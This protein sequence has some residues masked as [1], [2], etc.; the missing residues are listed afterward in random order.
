M[1][2]LGWW[3]SRNRPFSMGLPIFQLSSVSWLQ[4][5]DEAGSWSCATSRNLLSSSS[6][7]FQAYGPQTV[8]AGSPGYPGIPEPVEAVVLGKAGFPLAPLDASK[9]YQGLVRLPSPWLAGYF[10][11]W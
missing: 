4:G 3:I 2:R 9:E 10:Q 1:C 7:L 5:A 6:G 8:I 11:K